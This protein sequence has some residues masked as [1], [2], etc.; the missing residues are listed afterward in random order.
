M[1]QASPDL[2]AGVCLKQ[3][4]ANHNKA[5]NPGRWPCWAVSR[6]GS[7]RHEARTIFHPTQQPGVGCSHGNTTIVP[8]LFLRKGLSALVRECNWLL[9]SA[10]LPIPVPVHTERWFCTLLCSLRITY[11]TS[12]FMYHIQC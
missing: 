10:Q 1:L 4:K 2:L 8:S 12:A 7:A 3:N 6:L 5:P 9:T 11:C